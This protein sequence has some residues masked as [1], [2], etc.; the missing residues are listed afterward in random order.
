MPGQEYRQEFAPRCND[1]IPPMRVAELFLGAWGNDAEVILCSY[2]ADARP[3]EIDRWL[4]TIRALIKLRSDRSRTDALT[5]MRTGQPVATTL[6]NRAGATLRPYLLGTQPSGTASWLTTVRALIK[7]CSDRSCNDTTAPMRAAQDL[8][9]AWGDQAEA[10]LC[11]NLANAER[12]ETEE[13]LATVRA[14]IR[15]RSDRP[16]PYRGGPHS[17]ESLLK[18]R[19]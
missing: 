18:L 4:I 7:Q 17:I 19:R 14:L 13:W 10:V 3:S 11:L 9:E 16:G 12:S 6:N 1:N 15:L 8:V 2:L 5:P